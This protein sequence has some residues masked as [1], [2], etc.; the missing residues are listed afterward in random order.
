[1]TQP[2]RPTGGRP[3]PETDPARPLGGRPTPEGG[4]P[5]KISTDGGRPTP[6]GEE[7]T[8]D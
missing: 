1:M 6:E 2:V 4:E 3:T 5:V 8:N 7:E